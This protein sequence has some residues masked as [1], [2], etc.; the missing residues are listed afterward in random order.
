MLADSVLA[1]RGGAMQFAEQ[2]I[3]VTGA[4]GHL[5]HA[6]ADAFAQRG[7]NLVLVARSAQ[8]LARRFGEQTRARVHVAADLTK[9]IDADEVARVALDRFGR[10]DVLCNLAGGFRAG[11]PVH[12]T[13]DETW[14]FLFAVNVR[15][16]LC[17]SRA[18]VPAMLARQRG[19][20]VSVAAAA[21][22]QGGAGMGAYSA[23]K[24]V[25]VRLTE[26]MSAE[27]RAQ[28][29]NVNCVL[30][31]A[32]DTPENRRDMPDVDPAGFVALAD[33]A[34]IIVF[35]ASPAAR[36]IHGAAIPVTGLR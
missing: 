19:A 22:Q 26:S 15:T 32:L 3:V 13:P 23:S 27:L 33:L 21:A 28:G 1:K 20:I 36:P 8:A 34:C 31:T 4:S 7:A 12:E 16:M 10:I 5:G 24:A 17:A 11:E 14:E 2:T 6:V 29:I 30:P 18:I 35:L 25:V 9:Q